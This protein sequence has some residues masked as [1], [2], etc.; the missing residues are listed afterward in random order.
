MSSEATCSMLTVTFQRDAA[1]GFSAY[2]SQPRSGPGISDQAEHRY[3]AGICLKRKGM[4]VARRRFEMF[5]YRQIL[6][7]LRQGDTDRQICAQRAHGW[8]QGGR[9]SRCASNTAGSRL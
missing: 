3:L 2:R 1:T 5:Q 9:L 4:A 6:V 7:R 8:A